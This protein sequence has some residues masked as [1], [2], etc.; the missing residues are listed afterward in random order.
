MNTLRGLVEIVAYWVGYRLRLGEEKVKEEEG[1]RRRRK[2]R[3]Q[4][5]RRE[6]EIG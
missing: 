3:Q 2:N 4:T 6:R 5:K 1:E